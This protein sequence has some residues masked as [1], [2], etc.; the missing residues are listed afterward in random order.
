MHPVLFDFTVPLWGGSVVVYSMHVAIVL[1][2]LIAIVLGTR[3]ARARQI[4]PSQALDV[5]LWT[6]LCVI[7][8][9]RLYAVL[10]GP[11]AYIQD[12]L[13]ILKI[14]EGGLSTYGGFIGVAVGCVVCLRI[15]RIPM[16]R[17]MDAYV[18]YWFLGV[19]ITRVGDFLNGTCYGAP[20]APPLG[21]AYPQGSF[22]F[23]SHLAQGLIDAGASASMPVHPTQLYSALMGLTIFTSLLLLSRRQRFDGQLTVVG[24][25]LYGSIRFWIDFL[26]GDLAVRG[27]LDLSNTQWTGIALFCLCVVLY[28]HLWIRAIRDQGGYLHHYK[29]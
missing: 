18:P 21:L 14:W 27:P 1:S 19:A 28:M 12:P 24:G 13:K 15:K 17:F 26:R 6:I 2:A 22:P 25:L 23:N 4:E 7:A 9:A 16:W 8:G 29:P 11:R 5:V 10:E 3:A 20:V